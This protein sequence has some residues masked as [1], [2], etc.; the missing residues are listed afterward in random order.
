MSNEENLPSETELLLSHSFINLP[1]GCDIHARAL[2]RSTESPKL[3]VN[4]GFGAKK[5]QNT[6]W[7]S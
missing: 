1:G 4:L 7:N 2:K 6:Q 3:Y 5:E